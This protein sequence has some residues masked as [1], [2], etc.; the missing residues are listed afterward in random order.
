[1]MQF[2]K[3]AHGLTDCIIYTRVSSKAQVEKGQGLGSQETYCRQFASWK[4]Y[5][6]WQVFFDSGVSGALFN[7]DGVQGLLKFLR[8][9]KGKQRFVVVVDDI[10]RVARDIRVHIALRDA[11]DEC[12]AVMES[13][14][15]TFGSDS[16]GR[17]AEFMQALGAQYFR[18]QNTEQTIKR[19]TARLMDGYWPFR[20]PFGYVQK[21]IEGHGKVMVPDEPYASMIREGLEGFASGR[22]ETQAE[23]ARFFE[24]LPEYPKN[25]FGVVTNEAANRILTRLL[26][27]GYIE[28]PR[29]GFSLREGK[30]EGLITLETFNRIQDRLNGNAHV[31]A[32]ADLNADF[33]LRGFV[34]CSCGK[35]LTGSWSTSKTGKKHP[36]YMCYNKSCDA[37]RKSIPRA[38]LEG[39]FADLLK[40][41]QPSPK[42]YR[43]GKAILKKAWDMHAERAAQIKA[44]AKRGITDLENQIT[45][46]LDRILK[47]S[48]E[49]VLARF[50]DRIAALEKEKLAMAEKLRQ[51]GQNYRPFDEMFEL[52]MRFFANPCKIWENGRLEHKR[53]VLKLA[54]AEPPVY[55]RFGGFRT[56]KISIIFSMLEGFDGPNYRMADGVGFEPTKGVNPC[57]FSRPVP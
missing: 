54:F 39:D 18:E 8:E 49:T 57:R 43:F 21:K 27:S 55:D 9:H 31:P 23:V 4:G 11:I 26:Y 29:W 25:R 36:Y 35:P 3:A 40:G 44:M 48:N 47:V 17:Y 12:H 13:P 5:N 20:P 56:P 14:S 50:E 51:D 45:A 52:A 2:D 33:P 42:M 15:I 7:R 37:N 28:L 24:S 22:F 41:V 1:M 53:T 10:S 38:S 30:H 16:H 34:R 6:V 46:L 32:R 19:Q